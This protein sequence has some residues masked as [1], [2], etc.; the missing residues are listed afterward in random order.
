MAAKK[1]S[2]KVI[3]KDSG[4]PISFV[5]VSVPYNGLPVNTITDNN[6]D[7][8]VNLPEGNAKPEITFKKEGY[9]EV[10]VPSQPD[11][12]GLVYALLPLP[13]QNEIRPAT[14][15]TWRHAI[16]VA[17]SVSGVLLLLK[18]LTGE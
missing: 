12:P 16:G 4:Q 11:A 14:N 1:I 13:Q 7:F 5:S 6:G 17:A 15:N 18:Y 10:T 2:G 8:I 3:D 9:H